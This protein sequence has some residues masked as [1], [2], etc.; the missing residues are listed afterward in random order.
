MFE[1]K[2]AQEVIGDFQKL[3]DETPQELVHVRLSSDAWTLTEIVGHLV[4]S[5]SNNHQRF[6]WLRQGNLENFPAYDAESWVQAQA[7]DDYD[8]TMLAGLWTHY[9]ALIL[10]LAQTTPQGVLDNEWVCP[11][12]SYSLGFL[13]EDYYTHLQG[14]AEHYK[15]RLAEVSA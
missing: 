10:Y 13:I 5:A 12:G 8:F 14:H 9:N 3:I 4:D 2:V 7:Y 15:E 11:D 6:A 1:S